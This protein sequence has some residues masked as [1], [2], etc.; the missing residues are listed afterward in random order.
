MKIKSFID[1]CYTLVMRKVQ[2][3]VVEITN[4]YSEDDVNCGNTTLNEDAIVA[5]LIPI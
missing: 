4:L 5:V 2:M 1:G 3:A